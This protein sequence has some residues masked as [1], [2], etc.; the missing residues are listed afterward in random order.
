MPID[1]MPTVPISRPSRKVRTPRKLTTTAL[2]RGLE[3]L[4]ETGDSDAYASEILPQFA[5]EDG[6]TKIGIAFMR[7]AEEYEAKR[8]MEDR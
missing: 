3:H 4:I 1:H 8:E 5:N 2:Y 7:A 6:V